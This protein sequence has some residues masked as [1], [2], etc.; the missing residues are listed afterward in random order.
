QGSDALYLDPRRIERH[1]KHGQVLVFR[2]LRVGVGEQKD[3]LGVLRVRGEHLGAVDDPRVTVPH[4]TGLAGSDIGAALG[5]CVAQTEPD[6]TP[7]TT[8]PASSGAANC[9]TNRATTEVVP[10]WYQGV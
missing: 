6:S 2:P 8:L 4:R 10:Q 5:L 3:I 7:G 9:C 1:Q